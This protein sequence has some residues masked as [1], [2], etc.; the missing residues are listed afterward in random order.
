MTKK[1]KCPFCGK[2]GIM[3]VF[4]ISKL[5]SRAL[6][7]LEAEEPYP[8]TLQ[9]EPEGE[10]YYCPHCRKNIWDGDMKKSPRQPKI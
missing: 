5:S 2:P 6:G 3:R 10:P 8:T 1:L 9:W 7:D 4:N